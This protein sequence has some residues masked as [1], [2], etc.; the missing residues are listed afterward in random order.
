MGDQGFG[1]L[2][3]QSTDVSTRATRTLKHIWLVVYF[4][5]IKLVTFVVLFNPVL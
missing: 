1:E 3:V 5:K 4:V 2:T